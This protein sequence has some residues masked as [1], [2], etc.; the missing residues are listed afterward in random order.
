ME[1]TLRK[2]VAGRMRYSSLSLRFGIPSNVRVERV[3][4][5]SAPREWSWQFC[6]SRPCWV[7]DYLRYSRGTTG[8]G[9]G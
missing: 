4:I 3:S 7:W 5:V 6:A 8:A 1:V 2:R 9:A